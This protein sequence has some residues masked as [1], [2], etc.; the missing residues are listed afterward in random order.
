M[1]DL[2]TLTKPEI[3][4]MFRWKCPHGHSG[5]VHQ[6]CYQRFKDLLPQKIGYWDIE[7]SGLNASFDYIIS[8]CILDEDGNTYGRVL[9]EKEITDPFTLDKNLTQEICEDLR[10]F[11]R[12]YVWYGKSARGRHDSNFTRTRAVKWGYEFPKDGELYITDGF[13]I[14]RNKL[15][16]HSNRLEAV[17]TFLKIPSK[18]HK[19]DGEIWVQARCGLEKA[20]NW[21]WEHNAEDCR[22]LKEVIEKIG[23]YTRLTKGM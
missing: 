8:S 11:E 10:K 1:I 16:M 19:L 6:N 13:D 20:R 22:T 9:T 15:K 4:K 3:I 14:S 5:I 17:A 7:T 21:I 23:K 12:V 18:Q 2:T